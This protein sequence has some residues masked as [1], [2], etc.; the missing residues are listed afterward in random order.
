MARYGSDADAGITGMTLP[1]GHLAISSAAM[2][3]RRRHSHRRNGSSGSISALI[4]SPASSSARIAYYPAP[5]VAE[6]SRGSSR[7]QPNINR[8]AS[9][10][11]AAAPE[12]EALAGMSGSPRHVALVSALSGLPE[13]VEGSS[14]AGGSEQHAA[15]EQDNHSADLQ[16]RSSSIAFSGRGSSAAG[17]FITAAASEPGGQRV[18]FGAEEVDATQ[19]RFN[20]FA[21]G[22]VEA[23][24]LKSD[25][26]PSTLDSSADDQPP[27]QSPHQNTADALEASS[28]MYIQSAAAPG[29][30]SPLYATAAGMLDTHHG[31]STH[32]Q[33]PS[34]PEAGSLT[35]ASLG[36]GTRHHEDSNPS[37]EFIIVQNWQLEQQQPQQQQSQP[38]V[39]GRSDQA[40]CQPPS[41]SSE[42]LLRSRLFSISDDIPERISPYNLA[43]SPTDPFE[44]AGLL[45]SDSL[46]SSPL[47]SLGGNS[48]AGGSVLHTIN[49]NL[50]MSSGTDTRQGSLDA[51]F[52]RGRF[53]QT[54]ETA[55]AMQQVGEQDTR[56][57]PAPH[58]QVG[59][60]SICM[61]GI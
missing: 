45:A 46:P 5:R 57:D 29:N 61:S 23:A 32:T 31:G 15:G 60:Q 55:E 26:Q 42:L 17:S 39:I 53:L 30:G 11:V 27:A 50:L 9:A 24:S 48:S 35:H 54:S 8:G 6:S 43:G 44:S 58:C 52:V 41:S 38:Q 20:P 1:N 14:R 22:W 3:R 12:E 34:T 4:C 2:S 40:T 51:L 37:R 18:R 49:D 33:S 36:C 59:T 10:D 19:E 47:C 56:C 16:S 21:D 7:G 28:E 25:R 13:S